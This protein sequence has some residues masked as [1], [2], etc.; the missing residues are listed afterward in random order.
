MESRFF[1]LDENKVAYY[2]NDL[3]YIAIDTKFNAV[4][5]QGK[6]D[7]RSTKIIASLDAS[8]PLPLDTIEL[9]ISALSLANSS[10]DSLV[11]S[12]R[13]YTIPTGVRSEASK[14]LAWHKEHHRG[15]TPVGLGTART[16]AKGGQIGIEKVRHIAKYFPRHEVDKKGKG[17]KPGEDNFPSN[18]RI[19]WALW[20]GDA[21]WR[22]AKAIVERENVNALKADAGYSE[23][24]SADLSPLQDAFEMDD[25]IAPDFLARVRLDGS[26]IDR[27]YKVDLD[28]QVYAWDDGTWD[29]LGNTENGDIWAYDKALDD[30][31]DL[32]EKTHVQID[33]ES[34]IIICAKLNTNPF[35]NI[36]IDEIDEEEARIAAEAVGEE[37]W[38]FIDMVVTAAG[39]GGP[40]KPK[41]QSAPADG[42]TSGERAANASKQVRDGGGRFATQGK[43][44]NVK[45]QGSGTI[46]NVDQGTGKVTVKMANGQ[47]VVVDAKD[48]KQVEAEDIASPVGPYNAQDLQAPLDVSGILGEPRTP[49]NMPKAH[50]KGT[51]PPINK[52]DLHKMLAD[53]P[54][55]VREQRAQFNGTPQTPNPNFALENEFVN[56]VADSEKEQPNKTDSETDTPSGKKMGRPPKPKVDP[57]SYHPLLR[58]WERSINPETPV[59]TEA[60]A[61]DAW[62]KPVLAAGEKGKGSDVQPVYLAIVSP[63]D[64]R[65]VIECVSIVPASATSNQPMTYVRRNKKWERDP[66]FL[67]D[68]KSATPPPVVPLKPE[69]LND[70]LIQIDGLTASIGFSTDLELMVLF[71][72]RVEFI[73]KFSNLETLYAAGGL[74]RNRG[75]AENLRQYW[76]HGKGAAKIRWGTPGDWTRCVRHLSKFMGVRAKG[77][78]QLRHKE[79]TGMYTATH[80]KHD[81]EN[82]VQEF[83][84]E[85]VITKNYGKP[86]VV[87]DRDM[88]TPLTDIL[89][90]PKDDIYDDNWQ[91]E[92]EIIKA[93]SELAKCSDEEFDALVAAGVI[94]DLSQRK[95]NRLRRYW[96]IGRGG[97]RKI[98]WNTGGDWTRCVRH[99]SKYLGPRA[100]GY[101]ALRHKEMTGLWTGDQE[102]IQRFGGKRSHGRNHFSNEVI[103]STQKIIDIAHLN[104]EKN[105][106]SN[107]VAIVASSIPGLVNINQP[108]ELGDG[109]KFT[110][111]LV[112][113]ELLE[114]G[115]GRKFRK[116]AITWRELPLPLMW[117]MKTGQGHDGSVV[118]GR[119]DHLER[120]GDG[121]GNCYGVFDTSPHA[122][123]VARLIKNGFIRG[124]SADMDKFEATEEKEEEPKSGDSKQ[125][126]EDA[127]PEIDEKKVGKDK[128][129][130]NK[131]RIMGITIVPKPAFQECKIFLNEESNNNNPQKENP[132]INDGIY[133][134]D[135]DEFDAMSL[136]ACGMVAG[137][138]PINPPSDWFKKPVLNGPTP[139]TVTDEGQ[140]YGHIASWETD[141][142][143]LAR[144]TKPPRSRSGYSYFHTGVCRTAEGTDIPVGQLTLAGG[145]ASLEASASE[146]VKH[147]D[148]T[149]SAVAD[150]HAGEDQYGIFV[151][152]ALRPGATPD[153]I[154]SLRASAPSGDWRPIR[155]SLEL[156]AVCQVNVPGFPIARARVA[157]GAVMALVAAGAATLAKMKSD[158]VTELN[159][160]IKKLEAYSVADKLDQVEAIKAKF[161][162]FK[163]QPVEVE[164]VDLFAKAQELSA[165]F[166][167]LTASA[168]EE[169]VFAYIPMIERQKL[170]KSGKALPGGSFPI[171]D[172]EDLQNAIRSYGRAKE[173]DRSSVKRHIIKRARAL[174]KYDLVPED[175][176]KFSTKA[177]TASADELKA[178]LASAE[179]RL[180]KA[181]ATEFAEAPAMP[182]APEIP[183]GVS[184]VPQQVAYDPASPVAPAQPVA[185]TEMPSNDVESGLKNPETGK[186]TPST[187]PRDENG[188]F[189]QVLARLKQDLGTAGLQ[190]VLDEAKTV[191]K[192]HSLGSYVEAA[193]ASVNL[194]DILGRLDSG[195]LNNKALENVRASA[196]ELGTVI[197]NLPLGFNNQAEKVRYSDLPPAL[198]DLMDNMVTKVEAKIGKEDADIATQKLKE[199][200]SGSDVFNQSNISSEMSKLLRLLT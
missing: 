156:V 87:T 192:L 135:A 4:V 29:D 125:E 83:I 152:G 200:K 137:A 131:A 174:G 172:T 45:G 75:N 9:A 41:G 94:K 71:G 121:I 142:I 55:W 44:V 24:I 178:R 123:E 22:W 120:V 196:K 61:S 3:V 159:A 162:E 62:A 53:F 23:N 127:K 80:A 86:T 113:P 138:I 14:A 43:N 161:A 66:K 193:N 49:Q 183:S 97:R 35:K 179:E 17:W 73:E 85:E 182:V 7:E 154:R 93:L 79:A 139:L 176:K 173:S 190:R 92:M 1:G 177:V 37:D 56:S 68:L 158:P 51:Y 129:V 102:H 114:S 105:D 109:E 107:K 100:K 122:K 180:G 36:S 78:C 6:I 30:P 185:P 27:I 59:T 33:P 64:P 118:V 144:G 132:V 58:L 108:R 189:R 101:C 12:A 65:A 148:D 99:L 126:L 19:A 130:I 54:S 140:V 128:I 98:K 16:L 57:N 106:L 104:A 50:L 34:A 69:V 70:V 111:P 25:S 188:K 110:I 146:A 88:M 166:Q 170:A 46:T 151:A 164:E 84:M 195:A 116:D 74:D 95:A 194:Q 63:D 2:G 26:G 168:E 124:I 149:A 76:A 47:S 199:F 197:A 147:Y 20:G 198:R 31:Y 13:L 117:Q 145:H 134:D 115:D 67:E 15:G 155:G 165:K 8:A 77:Y 143:G 10:Q 60:D 133:V 150:V 136:I 169:D 38:D 32:V 40:L 187:Q 153:Q 157:S 82:S 89:S 160:R 141:H 72:P 103:N 81:R 11:A 96:T 186:Y 39:E 21:A 171:R 48:T 18:G 42:Y 181:Q 52:E 191:D 167:T 112:I 28:G 90:Q 5:E 119:I 175:W 184:A 163:V 91:P